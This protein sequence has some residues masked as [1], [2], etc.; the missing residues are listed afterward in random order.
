MD[1]GVTMPSDLIE[2]GSSFGVC[3]MP[4]PKNKKARKRLACRAEFVHR[5]ELALAVFIREGPARPQ[6]KVKS[7]LLVKDNE[8]GGQRQTLRQTA[9]YSMRRRSTAS[10]MAE[11]S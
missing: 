6:A 10:V 5:F 1:C 8:L 2:D 3:Q 4:W 7:A 9:H 11:A